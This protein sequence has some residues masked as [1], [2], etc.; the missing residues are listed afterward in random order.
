MSMKVTMMAALAAVL[1]VAADGPMVPAPCP[2][3][4]TYAHERLASGDRPTAKLHQAQAWL[5]DAERLHQAGHH[6]R[7]LLA[8]QAALV[9]LR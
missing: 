8:V 7:S 3:L 6:F 9:G 4:I 5:A 2:A 1:I